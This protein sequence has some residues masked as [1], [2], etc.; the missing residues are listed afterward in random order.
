M[1]ML[2]VLQRT[3][4]N[5]G[6]TAIR[7][8]EWLLWMRDERQETKVKSPTRKTDVWATQ[9]VLGFIVCATRQRK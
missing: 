4:E 7:A 5:E 1:K 8:G 3:V 2:S 6:R 9:F